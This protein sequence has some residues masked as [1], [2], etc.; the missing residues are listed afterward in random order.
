MLLQALTAHARLGT[1]RALVG[2]LARVFQDV[3]FE[4]TIL[5]EG[6]GAIGTLEWPLARVSTYVSLQII[7]G[8]ERLRAVRTIE[9]PLARV[10]T[11]VLLQI[12]VGG[13]G[14][15]TVRANERPFAG[16]STDVLLQVVLGGKQFRAVWA[17]ECPFARMPAY[18]FLQVVVRRKGLR[19][20]WTE[21]GS[22]AIARVCAC[23]M[24]LKIAA[25]CEIL[26]TVGALEGLFAAVLKSIWGMGKL[27][28]R[29]NLLNSKT[30]PL[31]HCLFLCCL[32]LFVVSA[33]GIGAALPHKT[34]VLLD[35][36]Q[37]QISV[38]HRQLPI[39][40]LEYIANGLALLLLDAG[41]IYRLRHHLTAI[42]ITCTTLN[43][44][45]Q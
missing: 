8:C 28:T 44:L 23:E 21:K 17:T 9:G 25:R 33:A 1:V 4:I 10:A 19:A 39:L 11:D 3:R 36:D 29:S 13:K 31:F 20:G 30:V 5:G 26:G 2:L 45:I 37:A 35:L 38:A 22:L 18:V 34:H 41:H 6:L 42:N 14:L 12:V 15:G 7:V 27:M 16:V 40:I 32:P 24:H 43:R